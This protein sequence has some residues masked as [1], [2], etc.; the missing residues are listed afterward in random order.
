MT[1]LIV[2]FAVMVLGLAAFSCCLAAEFS[3]SKAKDMEID[4]SLCYLP[5]SS[6]FGLGIAAIVCLSVAQIAGTTVAA[7]RLFSGA[8]SKRRSKLLLP[9]LLLVLSWISFGLAATLLGTGTSMNDRQLY[10]RGWLNAECYLVKDGVFI[11][12]AVLTVATIVFILGFTFTTSME[13]MTQRTGPDE[14]RNQRPDGL[15][16]QAGFGRQ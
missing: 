11:G 16:K 10:G 9:I 12:S 7:A 1:I 3:K 2:S 4:G 13:R 14:E 6:A 15:Q 5:R 8:K